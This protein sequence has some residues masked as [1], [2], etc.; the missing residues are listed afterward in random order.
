MNP[1]KATRTKGERC[2]DVL[3]LDCHGYD[4][5]DEEF[6][7]SKEKGHDGFHGSYTE[8]HGREVRIEWSGAATTGIKQ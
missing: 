5:D 2:N 8:S 7:C 3:T 1:K 6:W 4:C